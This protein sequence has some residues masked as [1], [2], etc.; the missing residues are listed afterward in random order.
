MSEMASVML[1]VVVDGGDEVFAC[2]PVVVVVVVALV[3]VVVVAAGEAGGDG[4][5]EVA[6]VVELHCIPGA[7]VHGVGLSCVQGLVIP[8]LLCRLSPC[9]EL[10]NSSSAQIVLCK[11]QSV[12]AGNSLGI[13]Q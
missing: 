7:V 9:I 11:H 1:V 6:V 10:A 2:I 5:D 8:R 3:V 12:L 13:N 4:D